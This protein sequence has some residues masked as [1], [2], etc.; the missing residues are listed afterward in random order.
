MTATVYILGIGPGND[1]LLTVRAAEV[2]AAVDQV[3]VPVSR[4]GRDSVAF[5]AVQAQVPAT[6][7]VTELVFPMVRDEA[8]LQGQ[9]QKNC[10]LPQFFSSSSILSLVSLQLKILYRNIHDR[11]SGSVCCPLHSFSY[12]LN[13]HRLQQYFLFCLYDHRSIP[14]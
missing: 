8:V 2:L 1:K 4:P 5:G 3:F 14:S 13:L 9:Y 12:S 6:T 11:V 10:R 7:T